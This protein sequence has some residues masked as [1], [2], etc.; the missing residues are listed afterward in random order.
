MNSGLI[1]RREA[2]VLLAAGIG[3]T[4]FGGRRLFGAEPRAAPSPSP[5][6]PS[7]LDLLNEVAETILPATAKSEGA[8]A[9][10]VAGFMD[11]MVQTYYEDE[12]Q[13]AFVA[14]IGELQA[15]CRARSGGRSFLDLG[16]EERLAFLLALDAARP[17]PGYYRM[18]RQLT[19][20][21]YFTSEIGATHAMAHVAVPGRFEGIV[22]VQPGTRVWSS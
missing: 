2:L 4:V 3:G 6:S 13:A 7:D 10:N 18:I 15:D 21:G 22:K 11:E 1:N 5:L 12:E 17:Q 16:A 19:I 20:F 8:K 14:G 9:A